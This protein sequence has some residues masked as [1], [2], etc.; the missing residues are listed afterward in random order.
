MAERELPQNMTELL[1]EIGREWSALLDVVGKLSPE[2]MV[3]PDMGGWSPKDNLAHLAEW[4][5]ILLGYHLDN[6]PP[7]EVTGLPPEVTENWDFEVVNQSFFERNHQRTVGAVLE[8]LKRIYAEV[9]S[10]LESMQFGDLIRP[11]YQN[12]PEKQPLLDWVLGNTSAHFAEHRL[13]IEK[14]LRK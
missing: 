5:K 3:M 13:N 10:R 6:L 9:I 7:H 8:E 2:E 12:D 4:M 11:R 1:D 14:I